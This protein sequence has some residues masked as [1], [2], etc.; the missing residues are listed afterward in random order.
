MSADILIATWKE[1]RKGLIEEASQIPAEQFSFRATPE[2]RS[3]AE[4]LQHIVESQKTLVGEG[5]RDDGNLSRQTLQDHA[6]E[7]AREVAGITDKN[8]LLEVLRSSMETS[9]ATIRAAA[10]TLD[11][12]VRGLTGRETPKIDMLR[13]GISHEM[14]HRGQLTVFERL[15]K[16]E[17]A[18]TQKFNAINAQ[19]AANKAQNAS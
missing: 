15:L 5:T 7:Y 3:V 17:P 19:A 12:N 6:K 18:L 16:L 14:Y 10:D 11:R 9:E 13:F 4:L 8:G 2:T 1:V